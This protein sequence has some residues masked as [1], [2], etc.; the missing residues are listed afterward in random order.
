MLET[1]ENRARDQ[2]TA[3]IDIVGDWDKYWHQ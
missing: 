2:Y 3:A 1:F